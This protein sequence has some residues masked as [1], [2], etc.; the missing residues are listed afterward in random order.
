IREETSDEC[1]L[2]RMKDEGWIKG[3][4]PSLHPSSFLLHPFFSPARLQQA[5]L[6]CRSAQSLFAGRVSARTCSAHVRASFK[7]SARAALVTPALLAAL[8][9]RLLA[10]LFAVAAAARLL[11][12]VVRRVDGRP[13]ALFSLVLRRAARNACPCPC[14]S[15]RV[16]PSLP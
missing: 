2:G 3:S 6:T 5:V 13:R 9:V 1:V 14:L 11:A 10:L 4:S 7:F 16:S 12:A 8:A 15:T